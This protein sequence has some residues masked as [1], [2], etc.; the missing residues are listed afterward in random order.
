MALL[1]ATGCHPSYH[2]QLQVNCRSVAAA[3][4]SRGPRY[5]ARAAQTSDGAVPSEFGTLRRLLSSKATLYDRVAVTCSPMTAQIRHWSRPFY[6]KHGCTAARLHCHVPCLGTHGY[7]G[8]SGVPEDWSRHTKKQERCHPDSASAS[9]P[10]QS[11]NSGLGAKVRRRSGQQTLST[12]VPGPPLLRRDRSAKYQNPIP[13]LSFLA[14]S[15]ASFQATLHRF[16]PAPAETR[17]CA[18]F[19]LTRRQLRTLQAQIC[20]DMHSSRVSWSVTFVSCRVRET[21]QCRQVV[22]TGRMCLGQSAERSMPAHARPRL[23]LYV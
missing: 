8:D 13:F 10:L 6:T 1:H 14:R 15:T 2:R 16:I 11:S 22:M 12:H 23:I 5:W 4:S 19:G 20:T 7:G 3:G 9:R 21:R 17:S 18:R